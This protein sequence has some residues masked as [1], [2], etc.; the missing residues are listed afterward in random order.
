MLAFAIKISAAMQVFNSVVKAIGFINQ[1]CSERQGNYFEWRHGKI[2]YTVSG[3]G[4]PVVVVHGL[5]PG[6]SGTKMVPTADSLA[7]E[8]TVYN[9]DLLGFGQSEKPWI[10][11]TNYIYVLLLRDF[12]TEVVGEKADVLAYEGSGLFTLQAKNVCPEQIGKVTLVDPC[13]RESIICPK[14]SALRI[15]SFIELPLYGTFLYNLYCLPGNAPLDSN[16]KYVFVSRLTGH[17]STD[18]TNYKKLITPDVTIKEEKK[19]PD[20]S[21]DDLYTAD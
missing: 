14:H 4:T 20:L 19:I 11:Y 12:I 21:I 8:H 13:K 17:L 9:I 18:I 16:A 3:R 15:K 2:F 1:K 7:L 10:T 5:K 6:D